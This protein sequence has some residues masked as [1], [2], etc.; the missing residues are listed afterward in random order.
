MIVRCTAKALKLLGTDV[1]ARRDVAPDVN[2]WYLNL[3]WLQRRKCL[4]FVH[5]GTLF[6][7]L[8]WDVRVQ[9]I[10]PIGPYVASQVETALHDEGLPADW[11]GDLNAEPTLIARTADRQMLGF[12]NDMTRT[13]QYW[14]A[15]DPWS[16][17]DVVAINREL[18]RGVHNRGGQFVKP[19]DLVKAWDARPA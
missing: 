3:V 15:G 14:A 11:L 9:Q 1:P 4:L 16:S 6:P 12:M 7:V 17:R 13:L 19:L 2:D 8:T 5:V 18:R 10:R